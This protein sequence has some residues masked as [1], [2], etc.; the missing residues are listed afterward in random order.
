MIPL[1][2]DNPTRITPWVTIGLIVTNVLVFFWQLS[3]GKRVE[4]AVYSLGMIPAVVFGDAQ[5]PPQLQVV[6]EGMTI[7]TSMFLHGGWGHLIGNM[8]YLWIFGNNIED[9]MGHGRF[10]VFYL[11][12]GVMAVLAQALPNPESTIPM[13]GAS[14]AIS[15]VL[16][17]Y[18]LLYPHAR[19]LVGIPFGFYLHTMYI[20]AGMV[21]AFWFLLQLISSAASA[22]ST[23][24]GVA[25]GA[26]IG[27]F[28]AGMAFIPFFRYPHL[29]LWPPKPPH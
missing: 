1:H 28:V 20:P 18:L 27:G 25:F 5:L 6:P 26:H 21:L 2:D 19:V 8:L 24:G 10:I 9:A 15:G 16:G 4:L 22:G 23:G 17:A 7:F 13:I 11:L 3:L 29:K 12:C 14:G